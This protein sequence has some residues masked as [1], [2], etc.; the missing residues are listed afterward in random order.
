MQMEKA[1]SAEDLLQMCLAAL[2]SEGE[3][4]GVRERL[5][6]PKQD[7][8]PNGKKK[9]ASTVQKALLQVRYQWSNL[10]GAIAI[11]SGANC[12]KGDASTVQKALLQVLLQ[13]FNLSGTTAIQQRCQWKEG[14]ASTVQEAL[15]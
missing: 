9:D 15:F 13:W 3:E 2:E 12:K 1:C 11:N 8:G 14:D 4:A 6:L 10:P 7:G 5:G